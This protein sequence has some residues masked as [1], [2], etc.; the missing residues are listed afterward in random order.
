MSRSETAHKATESLDE[1]LER[2]RDEWQSLAEDRGKMLLD[3]AARYHAAN[4][5]L[6]RRRFW[7]C[8]LWPCADVRG[9]EA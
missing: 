3:L 5:Q 2:E 7:K 9:I 6:R 8:P 1:R 4:H